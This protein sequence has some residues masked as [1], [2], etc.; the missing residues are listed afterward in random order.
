[1]A[2]MQGQRYARMTPSRLGDDTV[3]V[4]CGCTEPLSSAWSAMKKTTVGR[5]G[6][7]VSGGYDENTS[8]VYFAEEDTCLWY[9]D[10]WLTALDHMIVDAKK[11][12]ALIAAAKDVREE[13]HEK[14]CASK[15]GLAV[16]TP[17]QFYRVRTDVAVAVKGAPGDL[18]FTEF[19]RKETAGKIGVAVRT[20]TAFIRLNFHD[21]SLCCYYLPEWLEK[22]DGATMNVHERRR[23]VAPHVC[24]APSAIGA[25]GSFCKRSGD[26]GIIFGGHKHAKSTHVLFPSLGKVL[27]WD[28]RTLKAVADAEVDVAMT[29]QL[30]RA[31]DQ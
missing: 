8:I 14:R 28:N 5:I 29:R 13:A 26:I 9:K 30:R 7:I 1:M 6:V 20:D 17:L 31:F 10:E 2:L 15:Q 4:I 3:V 25:A 23:L 16:A 27:L 12:T 24:Q 11:V 19:M 22:V 21:V 18:Q